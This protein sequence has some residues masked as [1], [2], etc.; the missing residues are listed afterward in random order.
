M[1]RLINLIGLRFGRLIVIGKDGVNQRTKWLCTCECG[2]ITSVLGTQLKDGRTQSCGCLHK[3]RASKAKRTHGLSKKISEYGI[4]DNMKK[5][6]YSPDVKSYKHYG[7]R[8]IKMCDRWKSS[9]IL[10]LADMGR[11]PS[12]EYSIDR[13]DNDGDY[14]PENCRWATRKEQSRNMRRN[15]LVTINGVTKCVTDWVS[16]FNISKGTVSERL[17]RGWNLDETLFIKGRQ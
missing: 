12:K 1:S 13:I 4:W 10:F 2:N 6:C 5:R 14:K 3:E 17:A 8:G 11:R 15:V 9:F 7:A 16:Y